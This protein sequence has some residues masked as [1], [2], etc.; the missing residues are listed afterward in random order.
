MTAG[1]LDDLKN[2]N[3]PISLEDM[4]LGERKLVLESCLKHFDCGLLEM[5]VL[6]TD[7]IVEIDLCSWSS[8]DLDTWREKLTP[9]VDIKLPYRKHILS[10]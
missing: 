8:R 10:Q 4:C 5:Y 7:D 2:P 9:A 3:V 1:D 6:L